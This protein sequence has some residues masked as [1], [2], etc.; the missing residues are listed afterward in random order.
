MPE[1]KKD[2][3]IS[4]QRAIDAMLQ[5]QREDEEMYGARIP[6]GFDGERAA[7]KLKELPVEQPEIT[8]EQVEEYCRPR[9]LSIITDD[10][11]YYLEHGYREQVGRWIWIKDA[12]GKNCHQCSECGHIQ[13]KDS[14]RNFCPSC[15]ADMRGMPADAPNAGRRGAGDAYI[16]RD[17]KLGSI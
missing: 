17:V 7:E 15:G 10:L 9:C 11:L 4:K 1:L 3:L 13:S 14:S 8:L 2:E 12:N 16:P 5:L 6:E